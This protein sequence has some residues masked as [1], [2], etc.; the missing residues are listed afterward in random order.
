[1][2]KSD[3]ENLIKTEIQAVAFDYLKELKSQNA[4]KSTDDYLNS[5]G[6]SDD[7]FDTVFFHGGN[8]PEKIER[9][10]G[11]ITIREGNEP[12]LKITSN[13]IKEFEASLHE[14]IRNATVTFDK[15]SNGYSLSATRKPNGEV[16]ARASGKIIFGDNG[17]IVWVY[18]LLSGINVNVI[19]FKIDDKNKTTLEDLYNNF[20]EWQTKWRDSLN[21]PSAPEE[22]SAPATPAPTAN[23]APPVS[24]GGPGI[25]P[26][27]NAA[28]APTA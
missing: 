15:Q 28:T 10:T 12:K 13:E 24:G 17:E 23:A 22:P 26:T 25:A 27:A 4:V 5:K 14:A 6:M 11:P 1:M 19:N 3:L 21:L 16:E 7:D 20:N 8:K 9:K 2:N 18:S